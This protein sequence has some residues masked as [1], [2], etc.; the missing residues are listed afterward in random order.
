[1]TKDS[2][3]KKRR[4]HFTPDNVEIAV[5]PGA[6]L[7][8]AAIAAGVHINAS[9]GGAGVCGTCKVLI[10]QGQVEST[11]TEKISE[12]EY[13]QG[14][15]QACQSRIITDLV[16][17]IPV[18]SRLETAVLDRE[19]VG[20]IQ[21]LEALATGWRFKPPLSKLFVELPP[22]TLKDNTG[23][24][25]RLLR[26]IKQ[27]YHLSNMSVD[28]SVVKKL[29]KVLRDGH[30]KVTVTTLITAAKPRTKEWRRPRVI[31]IEPGDTREKH[32]SLAF[33]IGTTGVRG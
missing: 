1:M 10:K 20:A 16:V 3:N 23:D 7:L 30:W 18:E 33:D 15:R 9:C 5:K 27:R 19:R 6:N 28:F 25:S 22:P 12:E 26:G 14:L 31:H 2:T 8:E 32:Y 11:R 13:E 17:G 24:L 29:A 21:P 4:V